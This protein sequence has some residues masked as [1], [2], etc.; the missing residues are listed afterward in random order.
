MNH[1]SGK[2]IFITGASSG[3]GWAIARE[4]AHERPKLVLSAR[5]E[6]LLK[7]L[8]GLIGT[9]CETLVL[10]FDVMDSEA[11]K[12]AVEK[13][14]AHYGRI[15]VLI[16]NA[17]ILANSHF[18]EQPLEEIERL[19]R[20]NFIGPAVLMHHTLPHMLKQKSGHIV[21]VS[22]I[23][24]VLG[25]P[26][27]SSYCATKFALHGLTEALRREYYGTGVTLTSFCPGTVDTPMI[28]GS[29]KNSRFNKVT[30]PRSP[31]QV[32]VRIL[33]CCKRATPEM[34]Y[35]EVPGFLAK[36]SK[37]FP[38]LVDFFYHQVYSRVHPV[39]RARAH[40]GN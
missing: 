33:N 7:E 21:N 11:C 8:A 17:G 26:F 32:A 22:S 2:V 27:V 38:G 14:I 10:P 6:H 24:G 23:G 1:L 13:V 20:T 34:I 16:N 31:E 36:L 35:G 12:K 29:K 18:H 37:F 15:D 19:D 4:A 9:Q 40:S 5:R 3:I 25:F 39:A 30:R 28:A